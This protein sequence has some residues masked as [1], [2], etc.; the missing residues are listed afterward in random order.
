MTDKNKAVEA[1]I[2]EDATMEIV[3]TSIIPAKGA[4]AASLVLFGGENKERLINAFVNMEVMLYDKTADECKKLA[5]KYAK[6]TVKDKDDKTGYDAVKS[7]YTELVKIRTSTDKKRKELND[8]YAKIKKGIDDYANENI[9]GVLSSTESALKIQKDKFEKW[10]QEEKDRLAKELA[11]RQDKRI[12]ELKEV[13]LTFDG[14]LYTLGDT[15][16]MDAV[17]IGKMKDV[18]YQFFFERVKSEK[19]KIDDAAAEAQRIADEEK[20]EQEA[21][22]DKL[23]KQAKDLRD[24]KVEAREDKLTDIGL[25]HDKD[26]EYFGYESLGTQVK[27]TYDDVA[28]MDKAKFNEWL[29]STKQ[30]IIDDRQRIADLSNVAPA[31]VVDETATEAAQIVED[32]PQTPTRNYGGGFSG[33]TSPK[34][35]EKIHDVNNIKDYLNVVNFAELPKIKNQNVAEIFSEY[36]AAVKAAEVF[37]LEKLGA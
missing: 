22:K 4:N 7:A 27:L 32:I 37:L 15:I 21:L 19:K 26:A 30:I 18:D 35:D 25:I 12:K 1:E 36:R 11:E 34:T 31:D 6:L 8:P 14:E 24:E 29:E 5:K 13:G 28:E 9:V 33:G 20:A 2:V 17:S 3:Q 10:E 23:A 16:S